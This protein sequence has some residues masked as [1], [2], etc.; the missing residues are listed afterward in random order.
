MARHEQTDYRP[1]THDLK[2]R[3]GAGPALWGSL[4][5]ALLLVVIGLWAYSTGYFDGETD[6]PANPETVEGAQP[7]D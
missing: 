7:V 3:K 4:G 5:F 6:V 2:T 1:H